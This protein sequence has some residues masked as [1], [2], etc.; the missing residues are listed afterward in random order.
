MFDVDSEVAKI[1][2]LSEMVIGCAIEVHR[3]IGPGLL[4]S[5]YEECLCYELSRTGLKFERQVPLPVVYK[6]VSLDCGDKLDLIV[7][8]LIVLEIK[9]V[10][11]LIPIHEAQLLSYL[12]AGQTCRSVAQFSLISDETWNQADR[13]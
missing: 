13:K 9:A 10:E 11:R 3:G 2:S 1:N 7:E 6:K 12:N 4:E 5:A 8:G